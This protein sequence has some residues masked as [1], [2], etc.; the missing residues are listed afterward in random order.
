MSRHRS[1]PSSSGTT[2][3]HLVEECETL[4]SMWMTCSFIKE[5]CARHLVKMEV[6]LFSSPTTL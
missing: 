2:P 5:S 1:L 3:G 4:K 6:K